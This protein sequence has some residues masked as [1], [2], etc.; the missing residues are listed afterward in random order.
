LDSAEREAV[1]LQVKC[2]V[3]SELQSGFGSDPQITISKALDL[4]GRAFA[5][6]SQGRP[7]MESTSSPHSPECVQDVPI[8][9]A[10]FGDLSNLTLNFANDQEHIFD[11]NN[12]QSTQWDTWL[13][14]E[15]LPAQT[16][17]GFRIGSPAQHWEAPISLDNWFYMSDLPIVA[18]GKAQ[19]KAEEK[20]GT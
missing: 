18:Q 19:E 7:S 4:V 13:Q 2:E 16:K 1:L 20:V 9:Y 6:L 5:N 12:A 8:R 10:D 17:S 15:I 14:S 3:I 11:F